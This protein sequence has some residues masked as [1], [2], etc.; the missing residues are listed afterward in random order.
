MY[1][2]Y[3][4]FFN[5]AESKL[6]SSSPQVLERAVL[7]ELQPVGRLPPQSPVRGYPLGVQ[8]EAGACHPARV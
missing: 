8:S 3:N 4:T 7:I 5:N 2:C 6:L 1:L